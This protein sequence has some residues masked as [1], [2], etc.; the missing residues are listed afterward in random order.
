MI[1]ER[2]GWGQR[3]IDQLP[4]TGTVAEPASPAGALTLD[5]TYSFSVHGTTLQLTPPPSLAWA[6]AGPSH[7][8][9]PRTFVMVAPGHFDVPRGQASQSW[10]RAAG[11][12]VSGCSCCALAV[13]PEGCALREARG[14]G[15]ADRAARAHGTPTDTPPYPCHLFNQH[16]T[17]RPTHFFCF[18]HLD[19]MA[20]TT[21]FLACSQG[22][23]LLC[24]M[25]V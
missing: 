1:L 23:N 13:P 14:A 5:R 24:D 4:L 11:F 21:P 22:H 10:A 8:S 9:T 15:H 6:L 7:F 19:A 16:V 17:R 2:A 20:V 3:S 25:T 18:I 12:R